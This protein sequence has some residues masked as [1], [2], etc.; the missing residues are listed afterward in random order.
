MEELNIILNY[1]K[2]K[3]LNTRNAIKMFAQII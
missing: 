2:T 1:G 3:I